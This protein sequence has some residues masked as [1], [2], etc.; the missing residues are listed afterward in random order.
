MESSLSSFKGSL[1]SNDGGPA[2]PLALRRARVHGPR[3][4]RRREA[5]VPAP[6]RPARTLTKGQKKMFLRFLKNLAPLA[7]AVALGVGSGLAANA[8]APLRGGQIQI[9]VSSLEDP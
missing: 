9:P 1:L 8:E 6:P 3:P 4:C 5:S 2:D 7:G